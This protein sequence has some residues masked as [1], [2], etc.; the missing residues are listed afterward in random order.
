MGMA[1]MMGVAMRYRGRIE[2]T[3]KTTRMMM[4]MRKMSS[5]KRET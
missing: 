1:G 4:T 5:L 3:V 2:M